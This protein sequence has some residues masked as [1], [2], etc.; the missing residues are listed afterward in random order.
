[1]QIDAVTEGFA[2]KPARSVETRSPLA[3]TISASVTVSVAGIAGKKY[4][5]RDKKK[6]S[7]IPTNGVWFLVTS[8]ASHRHSTCVRLCADLERVSLRCL[9]PSQ[10][11]LR[12]QP[13]VVEFV[14][15]F[16]RITH[17]EPRAR[18]RQVPLKLTR[19]KFALS[20]IMEA[21]AVALRQ[22]AAGQIK[23]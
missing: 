15:L 16:P 5:L 9:I 13:T 22:D 2:V 21:R 12:Q 3:E 4:Q 1:M 10:S 17:R 7:R 19:G 14:P 18:Q 8:P 6:L 23:I 11:V 20:S